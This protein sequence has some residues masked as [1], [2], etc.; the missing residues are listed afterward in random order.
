MTSQVVGSKLHRRGV[1]CPTTVNGR[2]L[3]A[4]DLATSRP[5][6]APPTPGSARP[7]AR[8]GPRLWVTG[9]NTTIT[10][11]PGLAVESHR[12]TAGVV[13]RS[14]T[15]QLTFR[16]RGTPARRSRFQVLPAR[17]QLRPGLVARPPASWCCRPPPGALEGSAPMAPSPGSTVSPCAPRNGRSRASSSA[18]SRCR[19]DDRRRHHGR[20]GQP[21]RKPGRHWCFGTKQLSARG[22]PVRPQAPRTPASTASTPPSLTPYDV[23]LGDSS[24]ADGTTVAD[25]DN[26][27][28]RRRVTDPDPVPRRGGRP[29]G[30]P[31]RGR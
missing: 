6:G 3:V 11:A 9:T 27:S 18:P 14:I 17:R 26:W 8:R 7:P 25:L 4:E 15:L 23:P 28:A 21:R 5:P 19:W 13:P 16:R 30:P 24:A 10:V 20:S 22:R 2:L 12:R 1:C 29:C 31:A